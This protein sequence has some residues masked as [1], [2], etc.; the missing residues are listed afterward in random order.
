MVKAILK[1]NSWSLMVKENLIKMSL[2]WQ[3]IWDWIWPI[4]KCQKCK[5]MCYHVSEEHDNINNILFYFFNTTPHYTLQNCWWKGK[6]TI[7]SIVHTKLRSNQPP[8]QENKVFFTM[9]IGQKVPQMALVDLT[10]KPS[11]DKLFWT[12]P[13]W[14]GFFC[15]LFD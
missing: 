8:L 6:S 11:W 3:W 1:R 4:N 14:L 5:S 2:L 9:K 7:T 10:K 13:F 15:G 12:Q